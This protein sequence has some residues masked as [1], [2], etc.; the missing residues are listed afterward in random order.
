MKNVLSIIIFLILTSF[1]TKNVFAEFIYYDTTHDLDGT[2]TTFYDSNS[3]KYDKKN[4]TLYVELV[5][6]NDTNFTVDHKPARSEKS[7]M[8]FD[9]FNKKIKSLG[10]T[11]YSDFASSGYIT[12]YDAM[13][14]QW[15]DVQNVPPL[16]DMLNFFCTKFSK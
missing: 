13:E 1:L 8:E 12:T 3:L 14:S 7:K 11:F 6:N 15:N 5:S 10:L 2:H 4:H 9:C 16:L